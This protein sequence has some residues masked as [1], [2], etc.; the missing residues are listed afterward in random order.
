MSRS[1]IYTANTFAPTVAAGDIVPFGA[2]VRRYGCNLSQDGN[3]ITLC[4]QGYYQVTISATLT[5][6]AAG[7]VTLTAQKDGVAIPGATASATAGATD[8]ALDLSITCIV[9]NACGCGSSLLSLV[10]TGEETVVNNLAVTVEK[11]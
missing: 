5:P 1:A 11:L 6:S 10:L 3:A 7:T 8:I 2:T 9:R 4:G